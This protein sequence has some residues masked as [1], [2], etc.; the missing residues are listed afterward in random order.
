MDFIGHTLVMLGGVLIGLTAIMV[1]RG[2]L[3]EKKLDSKVYKEIYLEQ[4]FGILGIIFLILGYLFLV[5]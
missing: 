1:H 4:I 5:L 3:K 2:I